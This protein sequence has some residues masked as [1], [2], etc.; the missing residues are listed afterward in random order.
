MEKTLGGERL[1]GGKKSKVHLHHYERSTHNMSRILRTTMSPGTL[2]PFLKEVALPGDTFDIELS[3]DI[4]TSP[5]IGPL[6]GS[7]QF[8]CD[9]FLCPM[10]LYNSMLHMN[11]LGIGMNMSQ[12]KLPLIE[13]ELRN[14]VNNTS[15]PGNPD[16]YQ[17]N[18]SSLL[19]YLGISGNGSQSTATA[20]STRRY[21]GVPYLAYWDIYK[22]YYANKQE[23]NGVYIH[24]STTAQTIVMSS[25]NFWRTN[26]AAPLVVPIVGP[27]VW[28]RRNLDPTGFININTT[29]L[30]AGFD[31]SQMFIRFNT[32]QGAIAVALTKCFQSFNQN[33]SGAA[34]ITYSEPTAYGLQA[35]NNWDSSYFLFVANTPLTV[36]SPQL[37]TFPLANIDAERTAILQASQVVPYVITR[38][39]GRAPYN[40]I[41][42]R[43]TTTQVS[44][45]QGSQ[46][47]LAVKTY[48]S[49][50]FNNWLSTEWIT[51]VPNGIAEVTK[52][53]TTG[54][55]FTIDEFL[56]SKKVYD[57]LN[58][59]AASGGSY[60]DWLDA[61]YT[62]DRTRS[63]E[64]PIYMGGMIKNI[65]FQEVVS[66]AAQA[67][68]PLGTL[69]GRGRLGD[70]HKGGKAIIKVDEP[71][72][73]IGICHITPNL[74][75]TQGNDWD[76]N[77]AT[78]NDLHKPALDQIG[79]QDLITDQMAWWDTRLTGSTPTFKSAGKQPAWINY[80]TSYNKA[81]G[82]FAIQSEQMFMVLGRR[83]EMEWLTNNEM[84]IS[85]LTTYIDPMKFNQIFADTRLDA[86]N[87]WVQ[88]G[89]QITA[90]RK[91][92]AKVMPN[93]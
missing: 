71:S 23:T 25:A 66:T 82:N 20:F 36:P 69:A 33:G 35:F 14:L 22:N 32:P 28:V 53:D 91:M 15:Q 40:T 42:E 58:R 74:D 27:D 85:D 16:N 9:L 72:Y 45:L 88:V 37:A 76:V 38:L 49:D 54:N 89:A 18:P 2:V 56:L 63:A 7:F 29:S 19:K 3:A 34:T 6:F 4:F 60:D 80:M 10:R 39:S 64:S 51:G 17:I 78:I 24:N 83:Y 70:K 86:M 30:S 90:R 92:S 13:V 59:I 11:M 21:N 52:V 50:I 8:Q 57:M 84:K 87:F 61:V 43:N 41:L 31:P 46:E 47:G 67:G 44:S 1:G 93:L 65:V 77:L 73:I 81:L 62:H 68:E 5:T 79:F 12:V 26:V 75:Y 55:S 48:K